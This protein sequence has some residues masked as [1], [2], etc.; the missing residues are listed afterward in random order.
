MSGTE[1]F[2]TGACN[3]FAGSASSSK[4]ITHSV[5]LSS[6]TISTAISR[7][8]SLTIRPGRAMLLRIS[9][10]AIRKS[11]MC[12]VL[13][14]WPSKNCRSRALTRPIFGNSAVVVIDK[15]G[16]VTKWSL[17]YQKRIIT[18]RVDAIRG[19][20]A[21]QHAPCLLARTGGNPMRYATVLRNEVRQLD[22][23]RAH[24]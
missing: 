10:A 8:G 19:Y 24:L 18:V 22:A 9:S 13:R 11:R 6:T 1:V 2:G 16:F 14:R 4:H 17:C 5:G 20:P 15:C 3:G 12:A 23:Q 7:F 21:K